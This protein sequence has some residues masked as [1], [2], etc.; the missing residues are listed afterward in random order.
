MEEDT[1]LKLNTDSVRE[2]TGVRSSLT[3]MNEIYV[4]T[5]DFEEKKQESDKET[6]DAEITLHNKV[7]NYQI[8]YESVDITASLFLE[9]TG[10]PIIRNGQSTEEIKSISAFTGMLAAVVILVIG[11]AYWMGSRRNRRGKRNYDIDNQRETAA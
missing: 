7:F 9:N 11:V 1:N 2:R 6:Q 4:F 10:E 3:D 8:E 5:D